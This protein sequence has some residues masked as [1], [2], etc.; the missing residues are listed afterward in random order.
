MSQVARIELSQGTWEPLLYE[1]GVL[2]DWRFNPLHESVT[3]VIDDQDVTVIAGDA[4][5]PIRACC[6]YNSNYFESISLEHERPVRAKLKLE[7]MSDHI[8]VLGSPSCFEFYGENRQ[9]AESLR[10]ITQDDA[11]AGFEL[12]RPKPVDPCEPFG[13]STVVFDGKTTET[14]VETAT[15]E[16]KKKLIEPFYQI[17]AVSCYPLLVRDGEMISEYPLGVGNTEEPT[18][19]NWHLFELEAKVSGVDLLNFYGG[20]FRQA[21]LTMS[22]PLTL[23]TSPHRRDP[24]DKMERLAVIQQKE[25]RTVRYILEPEE[26]DEEDWVG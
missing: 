24:I 25:T 23:H 14:Q 6:S 15:D 22:G 5:S 12:E 3:L 18:D 19:Q 11:E 8:D 9:K 10:M 17:G 4:S 1:A 7:E 21:I 20:E 26:P 16:V 2:P 13:E